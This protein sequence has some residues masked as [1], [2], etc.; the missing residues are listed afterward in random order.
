MLEENNEKIVEKKTL[1]E[2]LGV[3]KFLKLN[4]KLQQKKNIARKIVKE[5]GFLKKGGLNKYDNYE[6]F[7]EAQYKEL[8]N[9]VLVA[10]KLEIKSNLEEMITYENPGTKMSVGRRPKMSFQLHDTETGFYEETIIEGDGRDSGDKAGYKAYTGAIKYFIANTFLVA[11]GDDPEKDTPNNDKNNSAIK[12]KTNKKVDLTPISKE[13][14]EKIKLLYQKEDELK[15][16]FRITKK[17]KI[18]DL[19]EV[20]ADYFIK[21]K[22]SKGNEK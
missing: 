19:T 8:T 14:I 13:K 12:P 18:E 6:Y 3:E 2:M 9:E 4:A 15:E 22:N 16:I 1:L 7:T 21:L 11:T 20:M 17:E 5:K 10:A